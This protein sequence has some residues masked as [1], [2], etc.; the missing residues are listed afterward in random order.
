MNILFYLVQLKNEAYHGSKL[1]GFH[2]KIEHLVYMYRQ[3]LEVLI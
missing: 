2:K 1:E 3:D